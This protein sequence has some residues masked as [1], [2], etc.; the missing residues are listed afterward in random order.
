M[1]DEVHCIN[2][3]SI[4]H[5]LWAPQSYDIAWKNLKHYRK[6]ICTHV[7]KSYNHNKRQHK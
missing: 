5:L 3:L 4:A 6:Q 2:P 7:A 1:Y